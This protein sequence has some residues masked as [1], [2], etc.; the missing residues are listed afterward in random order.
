MNDTVVITKTITQQ[1]AGKLLN[2]IDPVDFIVFFIYSLMGLAF[3]LAVI[4]L[5][6]DPLDSRTP[7]KFSLPFLIKDNAVRIIASIFVIIPAILLCQNF[8]GSNATTY[9]SFFIGAGVDLMVVK[10]REIMSFFF[11]AKKQETM[12]YVWD[13][14]YQNDDDLFEYSGG[15]NTASMFAQITFGNID[16]MA[17]VITYSSEPVFSSITVQIHGNPNSTYVAGPIKRPTT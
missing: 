6:R 15:T 1:F 13:L 8:F 5:K 3:T 9:A 12:E 17:K 11:N 2:G 10:I 16:T 14:S 4:A 7:T